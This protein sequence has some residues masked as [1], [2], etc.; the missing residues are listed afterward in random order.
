[1]RRPSVSTCQQFTF[2]DPLMASIWTSNARGEADVCVPGRDRLSSSF[3]SPFSTTFH[4]FH[5]PSTFKPWN[6]EADE[7]IGRRADF[8]CSS[9]YQEHADRR[10]MFLMSITSSQD[11]SCA[12]Q[13]G[14]IGWTSSMSHLLFGETKELS[15]TKMQQ[16]RC[17]S[18]LECGKEGVKA[19][20][21]AE[22]WYDS[23]IF[24][25]RRYLELGLYHREG[26]ALLDRRSRREH[27]LSELAVAQWD[28]MTCEIAISGKRHLKIEQQ[29]LVAKPSG[30]RTH[31]R[32][33]CPG[34]FLQEWTCT[35]RWMWSREPWGTA[36]WLPCS[37]AKV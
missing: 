35:R 5:P 25:I 23:E 15:H 18:L 13:T 16:I 11:Y 20:L 34:K 6:S 2:R 21:W 24:R 10:G 9:V 26:G 33:G 7:P 4:P 19:E 27:F 37:H 8:G 12:K 31:D 32:E 3:Q 22:K 28:D 14:R 29:L 17:Q 1:M 30:F 36:P